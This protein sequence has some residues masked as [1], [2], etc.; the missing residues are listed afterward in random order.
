LVVTCPDDVTGLTC[1]DTLPDAETS[2]Q[3]SSNCGD[4]VEFTVISVVDFCTGNNL[5]VT[6]TYTVMDDCGNEIECVQTF[7]FEADTEGPEVTCPDD[8]TG[9]TC[10]DTCID[11]CS[12]AVEYLV[13]SVVDSELPTSFCAGDNLVVTRTYTVS[14][15]CRNQIQCVQTFTFEADTDGPQIDLYV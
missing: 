10:G 9:L 1:G 3:G 11:N 5:A 4:S 15:E 14:D 6:R 2:L 7:N 13:S 12:P 8:V